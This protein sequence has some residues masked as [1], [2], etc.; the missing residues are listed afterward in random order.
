MT[1]SDKMSLHN[2]YINFSSCTNKFN[3]P[4]WAKIAIIFFT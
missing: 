1:I 3:K 2:F 4:L